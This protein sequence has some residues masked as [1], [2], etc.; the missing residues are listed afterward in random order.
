MTVDYVRT[1]NM[2]VLR[3]PVCSATAT[4][5]RLC[6]AT[7]HT[8]SITAQRNRLST[9][10]HTCQLAGNVQACRAAVVVRAAAAQPAAPGVPPASGARPLAPEADVPG[11]SAYLD[12]L[13]WSSDGLVPVI[14]QVRS[15]QPAS[16]AWLAARTLV[17]TSSSCTSRGF[18]WAQMRS[19]R[20][21]KQLNDIAARTAAPPTSQHVDTGELL[22]QAY[23]NRA[24]VSE[25]LQTRCARM[26]HDQH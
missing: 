7:A 1:G 26:W 6:R 17:V 23:A 12:G 21:V 8:V 14:V 22:M 19:P 11:M 20:K 16:P 13:R 15:M 2:T 25:T 24:A 9:F 4:R 3:A 5:H 18:L 10:V